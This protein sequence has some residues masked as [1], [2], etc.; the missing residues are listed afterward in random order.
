MYINLYNSRT[1]CFGL[2]VVLLLYKLIHIV[3][4]DYLAYTLCYTHNGDASTQDYIQACLPLH[5]FTLMQVKNLQ[6]F[7]DLHDNF[8]FNM[9]IIDNVL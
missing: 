5:D 6:H 3:V 2:H 9:I 4:F 1:T 7:S 8:W